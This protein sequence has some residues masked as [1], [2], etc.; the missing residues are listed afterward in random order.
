MVLQNNTCISEAS[1]KHIYE[2]DLDHNLI[3]KHIRKE[4]RKKLSEVIS[5]LMQDG[6]GQNYIAKVTRLGQPK[7][8]L[9]RKELGSMSHA[10]CIESLRC[11]GVYTVIDVG[12]EYI[13]NGIMFYENNQTFLDKNK[14]QK[15]KVKI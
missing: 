11:L 12:L 2:N 15:T 3:A 7:I 10:K 9:L 1:S 6:L 5:K 14:M 4:L 8:S 13:P